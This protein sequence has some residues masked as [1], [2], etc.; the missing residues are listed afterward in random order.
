M[1]YGIQFAV[2]LL[3]GVRE[4]GGCEVDDVRLRANYVH[5]F[6]IGLAGGGGGRGG[7]VDLPD[8]CV[9]GE[10][11]REASLDAVEIVGDDAEEGV[12]RLY[13]F[14]GLGCVGRWSVYLLYPVTIV[15][16]R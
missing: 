3:I 11:F 1:T 8:C 10:E 13:S 7:L 12:V 14:V 9:V 2:G 16:H 6:V 5:N 4:V 15:I